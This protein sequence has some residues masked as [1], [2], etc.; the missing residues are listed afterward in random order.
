MW[1]HSWIRFFLSLHLLSKISPSA[2][3]TIHRFSDDTFLFLSDAGWRQALGPRAGWRFFPQS[4]RSLYSPCQLCSHSFCAIPGSLYGGGNLSAQWATG[5]RRIGKRIGK[6]EDLRI[7]PARM[8][9]SPYYDR[10][11][12]GHRLA[13]VRLRLRD[14]CS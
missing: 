7:F 4:N 11:S 9:L 3:P 2:S 12:P 1:C 10:L 14:N 6:E 8:N 13:Y 5:K